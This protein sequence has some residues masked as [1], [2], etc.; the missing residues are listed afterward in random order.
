MSE[1]NWVLAV[2]VGCRVFQGCEIDVL[3][4]ALTTLHKPQTHADLVE[5]EER[6][7]LVQE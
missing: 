4:G 5:D 1:E 3:Q 2:V 7:T 6:H